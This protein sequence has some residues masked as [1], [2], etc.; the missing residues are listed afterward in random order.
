MSLKI[1][2][3]FVI[4]YKSNH[5]HDTNYKEYWKKLFIVKFQN[6]LLVSIDVCIEVEVVDCG[7]KACIGE[8]KRGT[9]YLKSS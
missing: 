2:N 6:N 7:I 1:F 4:L 3:Q 9:H 5:E 8:A